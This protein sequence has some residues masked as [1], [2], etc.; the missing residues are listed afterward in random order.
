M[1]FPFLPDKKRGRHHQHPEQKGFPGRHERQEPEKQLMPSYD[2]RIGQGKNT[3]DIL[4]VKESNNYWPF[5]E[6]RQRFR[7]MS[8]AVPEFSTPACGRR[9]SVFLL[10][11]FSYHWYST[12]KP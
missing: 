8:H 7:K 5:V 4:Y 12:K 9:L 6:N 10:L 3:I 2:A 1:L 11:F